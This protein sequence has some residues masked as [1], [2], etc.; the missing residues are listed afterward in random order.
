MNLNLCALN[1][2]GRSGYRILRCG[3]AA[4]AEAERWKS[5]LILAAPEMET[6]FG[7][8]TPQGLKSSWQSS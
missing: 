6:S 8:I 1:P 2:G 7:H 3:A 5:L 4:P